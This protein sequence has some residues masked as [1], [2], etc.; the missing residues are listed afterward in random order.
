MASKGNLV[1]GQSGGPTSVIN[2]SLA[3]IVTEAKK[4]KAIGR[5]YGMSFAIEGFMKGELIDLGKLP[6]KT[7]NQLRSTP[8]SA[9]GSSRLKLKDEHFPQ[10]LAMLKKHDIRYFHLIGGNDSMD[11]I[12]RVE[13]YCRKEGYEL[14]GIGVPKTVD[15][16][17][18][19]TDHT[20]GYPSA[21]RY[22]ALSVLQSGLLA[23]DMMRVD[24]FVIYQSIGRDAGWLAA[25]AAFAKKNEADAPHI[26]VL[27]E[28]PLNKE[29]FLARV[30]ETY[31][32]HGF[33]SI[34]CGEGAVWENKVPVSASETKDKFGNTEFGAMGG[35]SCAMALHRI[36]TANFPGW[37]GE[38]QVTES[39]PMCA[40]DRMSDLDRKEAFLLGQKAVALAVKGKSGLMAALVREKNNPYRVK[41]DAVPL[42]DVAV[43][44][45][46]MLDDMIDKSG[47]M[48]TPKFQ[49][50]L[51]P[52]VGKLPQYARIEKKLI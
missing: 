6:S 14:F 23:R 38:F 21:A 4:H 51:R 31:R 19:G 7:L 29:R 10:V 49:E 32:K 5:I 45:K 35:T 50:Y 25:S 13:A 41:I 37:R 48:V 24:Q 33:V 8:S 11:T 28:R 44:A 42:S 17:L 12:H 22:T 36:I 39:L 46:P 3:G 34:V 18:F 20:P 30:E 1:V 43:R 16:D 47:F 9:L 52:L 40:A 2:G 27:P 26:L 15:N